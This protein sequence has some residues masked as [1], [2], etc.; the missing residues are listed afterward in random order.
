MFVEAVYSSLKN[1][2]RLDYEIETGEC[3]GTLLVLLHLANYAHHS[4]TATYDTAR[5]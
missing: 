3:E 2:P 1:P 4:F 5:P